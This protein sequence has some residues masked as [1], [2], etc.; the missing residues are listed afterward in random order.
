MTV[1]SGLLRRRSPQASRTPRAPVAC[2]ARA[3]FAM[4]RPGPMAPAACAL[5]AALLCTR[6]QGQIR[7]PRCRSVAVIVLL[8]DRL[9][10]SSDALLYPLDS[11]DGGSEGHRLALG[12]RMAW[13]KR[14]HG[15][16]RHAVRSYFEFGQ[17]VPEL[18][19][20]VRQLC[21]DRSAVVAAV[22]LGA[23]D[24][25]YMQSSRPNRIWRAPPSR[26]VDSSRRAP[27]TPL[28]RRGSGPVSTLERA[29]SAPARRGGSPRSAR[30]CVPSG[31]YS[32]AV[33]LSFTIRR[34]APTQRRK[35][36]R[37]ASPQIQIL[38]L[39]CSKGST[40]VLRLTYPHSLPLRS[41][42]GLS[43]VSSSRCSATPPYGSD[44]RTTS[45][46]LSAVCAGWPR[47]TSTTPS[48]RPSAGSSLP[49]SLSSMT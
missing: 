29:A 14:H 37:A 46:L 19:P 7:N 20:V 27:R 18:G 10:S 35:R 49:L 32:G 33:S 8:T 9:P 41:E 39:S 45:C 40:S 48:T 1:P 36:G 47:P 25:Q 21:G 34:L 43:A 30:N 31:T 23:Q 2:A 24:V 13:N 44:T 12:R 22:R 4:P 17:C 11:L 16:L 5:P 26:S 42:S 6:R 38:K 15:L 28:H 3:P